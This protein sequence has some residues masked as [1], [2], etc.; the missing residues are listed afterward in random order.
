LSVRS[1]IPEEIPEMEHV[2]G[3]DSNTRR[4]ELQ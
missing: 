3:M 1:E 2:Y 4:W